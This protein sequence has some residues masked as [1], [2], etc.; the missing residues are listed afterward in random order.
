MKNETQVRD[1]VPQYPASK[2]DVV[3]DLA[4]SGVKKSRVHLFI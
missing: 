3:Q 4:V 1:A 2:E